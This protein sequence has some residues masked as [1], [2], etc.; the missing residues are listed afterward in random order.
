MKVII[1]C[2][3]SIWG[4]AAIIAKWHTLPKPN[5]R[6]WS[7]IGYHY[8][9]L[10]GKISPKA[11]NGYFDGH[12]ETGRPLDDD[13]LLEVFEYGAHVKG[14]N[15]ESIGICLI[16]ESGNFTKKQIGSLEQMFTKLRQ[17]FETIE[18]SQHSDWD[19]NKPH[20]AG[21]GQDYINELNEMFK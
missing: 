12:I 14:L 17:Q 1:H 4:N 13:N 16:G 10:N 5:G 6:G 7:N 8:V 3:D 21:L 11:F 20:C 15:R 9:I 18:V 2:S 19:D